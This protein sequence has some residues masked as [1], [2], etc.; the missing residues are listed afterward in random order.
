[1][2]GR[3]IEILK[4]IDQGH[5]NK[6]IAR[7]LSISVDTVKWYLKSIFN[8]LCVVRRGQAIAEARRLRLLDTCNTDPD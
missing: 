6:E 1:M 7:A 2:K 5:S 3:E 4:L 8:K